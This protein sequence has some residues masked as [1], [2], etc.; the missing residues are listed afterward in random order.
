M[1]Y[2]ST[3]SEIKSRREEIMSLRNNIRDLQA[4]I[5]PEEVLDYKFS[6]SEGDVFLSSLFGEMDTLFVVHN[7][8]KSCVNC[9]QWAD[10]FNGVLDH[11]EDR[12]AFVV[13]TPDVPS[14]QA[15]FAQSRGWT[16]RMVSHKGTSFAED[17]GFTGE[18]EGKPSFWPGVSVFKRDGD[19][20]IRVSDASFGPGDDYNSV[21]NLFELIPEGVADWKPKF[22]YQR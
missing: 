9:T 11:L 7:M 15:K 6:T 20:V 19:K 22:Q 17:M 13:S 4:A 16:F 2:K 10:G 8:G 18:Y 21:L 1:T 3:M 14:V 12:A 5:E